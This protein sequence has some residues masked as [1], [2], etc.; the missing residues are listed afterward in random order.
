MRIRQSGRVRSL[1]SSGVLILGVQR[2][3]S[4]FRFG[5]VMMDLFKTFGLITE[6]LRTQK[7]MG[8]DVL[9]DNFLWDV[10][11]GNSLVCRE[12]LFARGVHWA[13][14][15]HRRTVEV[16]A[17]DLIGPVLL[18]AVK[19][20]VAWNCKARIEYFPVLILCLQSSTP[21]ERG[22]LRA[23]RGV[24]LGPRP[25]HEPDHGQVQPD[26][27]PVRACGELRGLG[28][29]GGIRFLCM[30]LFRICLGFCLGSCLWFCLG[31]V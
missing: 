30:V 1:L 10:A 6:T 15:D 25:R 27:G 4:F 17:T 16:S 20:H 21:G 19:N 13:D 24:Q 29:P 7:Q 31:F 18:A 14:V 12:A 23:Q 11:K 22:R 26:L 8:V 2:L 9:A 3:H 28:A 5:Q